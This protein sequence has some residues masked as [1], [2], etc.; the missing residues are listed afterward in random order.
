MGAP[1]AVGKNSLHCCYWCGSTTRPLAPAVYRLRQRDLAR[2]FA[3]TRTILPSIFSSIRP[4]RVEILYVPSGGCWIV[5][6]QLVVCRICY[7][8]LLAKP[9][10]QRHETAQDGSLTLGF[11]A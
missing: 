11:I 10:A 4:S 8:P 3:Y 6:L 5:V 2:V 9:I 1:L 7:R